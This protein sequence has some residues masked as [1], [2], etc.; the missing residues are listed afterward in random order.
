[1][2]GFSSGA[3]CPTAQT[4]RGP[5]PETAANTLSSP[6]TLGLGTTSHS[7]LHVL[8]A[9]AVVPN[10]VPSVRSLEP[11]DTRAKGD[12]PTR[13]QSIRVFMVLALLSAPGKGEAWGSRCS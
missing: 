5:A 7:P 3:Y 8:S 9:A 13:A 12:R 2:L 1:M 4:L 11:H 6:P 10:C